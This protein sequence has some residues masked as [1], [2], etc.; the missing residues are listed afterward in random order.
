LTD[1]ELAHIIKVSEHPGV[2][3][4]YEELDSDAQRSVEESFSAQT[5]VHYDVDKVC[6]L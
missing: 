5:I 2:V 3:D 1:I 6:N 4:G